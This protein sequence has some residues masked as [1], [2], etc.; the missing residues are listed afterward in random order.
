MQ[1]NGTKK[2]KKHKIPPVCKGLS[3]HFRW[4][5]N[6]LTTSVS[7]NPSHPSGLRWGMSQHFRHLQASHSWQ[8]VTPYEFA[9]ESLKNCRSVL[10]LPPEWLAVI[11]L[12]LALFSFSVIESAY[13]SGSGDWA[14]NCRFGGL[15]SLPVTDVTRWIFRY[16]PIFTWNS[17]M[18]FDW[19]I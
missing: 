19:M 10:L 11:F 13:K 12:H 4:T 15:L 8:Q 1:F 5:G 17:V 2:K 16:C 18:R 7:L 9:C 3:I 14:V 6:S